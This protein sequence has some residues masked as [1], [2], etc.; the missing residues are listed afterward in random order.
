MSSLQVIVAVVLFLFM[1]IWV[2]YPECGIMPEEFH[3]SHS[4]Y[5]PHNLENHNDDTN[6]QWGELSPPCSTMLYY[7]TIIYVAR[8]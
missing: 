1:G 7:F 4:G 6:R 5:N 3:L 2:L 8:L